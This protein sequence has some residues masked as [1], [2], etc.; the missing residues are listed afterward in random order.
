M[1]GTETT[2]AT[3]APPYEFQRSSGP[4][5]IGMK[6]HSDAGGSMDYSEPIDA[7]GGESYVA[8]SSV[9]TAGLPYYQDATETVHE[10][11]LALLYLLSNPEEFQRALQSHPPRGATT[12]QEWNA[13][14]DDATVYTAEQNGGSVVNGFDDTTTTPLPFVV[15]AD[16]AEVVLPQA[17]TA[18]QLFGIERVEGIELE[19]AAGVPALSQLFLRWL[20]LMPGG[21]HIN[22]I[23]PP[24]L[25]VMRIAGGRYRVTAAHRVVWTW[26]NEF[27]SLTLEETEEEALQVG[28]LVSMTI[29]D[30]FETD[31]NGKLLSYCPTFDNRN[32]QKTTQASEAIR[33]SS[34]RVFGHLSAMTRSPAATRM[35]QGVAT[36]TRMGMT[37][38]KSMAQSVRTQMGKSLKTMGTSPA[39]Q[40]SPAHKTVD[41]KDFEQALNDA[42][43][44]LDTQQQ[45]P[46][47]PSTTDDAIVT[48][49]TEGKPT[50]TTETEAEEDEYDEEPLTPSPSAMA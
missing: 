37:A 3:A 2:T 14:Y 4:P 42:E 50:L 15:F 7:D 16:D 18:S 31:N 5:M 34:H 38:A 22:L 41:A 39:R 9:I 10:M 24:G 8:A 20:A 29:V 17:H 36:V 19:A 6:T 44:K 21:D 33:K 45:Q 48:P 46:I 47:L 23:E 12:L 43:A 32:I 40:Q 27:A 30:V 49:V 35:N 13:E 26:M 25:T 28:E 1:N 11:H